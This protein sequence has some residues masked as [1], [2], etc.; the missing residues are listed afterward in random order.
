MQL[1]VGHVPVGGDAP[2]RMLDT[3]AQ[4]K[5]SGTYGVG[6]L[7]PRVLK[8]RGNGASKAMGALIVLLPTFNVSIVNTCW[9][10]ASNAS[11]KMV[12]K[13]PRAAKVLSGE[14]IPSSQVNY[15]CT[16]KPFVLHSGLGLPLE[17]GNLFHRLW[18]RVPVTATRS[19]A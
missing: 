6:G 19:A 11:D 16:H 13:A 4:G 10:N 5:S 17:G 8:A 15:S 3:M 18:F 7:P 1:P 14:V 2:L 12:N 9:A